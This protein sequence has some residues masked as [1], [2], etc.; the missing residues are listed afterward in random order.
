MSLILRRAAAAVLGLALMAP[1]AAM[2][3]PIATTDAFHGDN[4]HVVTG[5]AQII[6]T[7]HG[8]EL[9]LSDD[10][11]LDGAPDPRVVLGTSEG[12]LDHGELGHLTHLTGAQIYS[13]PE[14]AHLDQATVLYIWCAEFDVSLG[15]AAIHQ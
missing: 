11:S 9:H 1:V 6:D 15:H 8:V 14:G 10:F 12:P 4:N 2:A 7:G 5:S 3:D 13:V